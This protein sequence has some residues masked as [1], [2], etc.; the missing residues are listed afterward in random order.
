MWLWKPFSGDDKSCFLRRTT[1]RI[2]CQD[3]SPSAGFNLLEI[4]GMQESFPVSQNLEERRNG[5][6]QSFTIPFIRPENT[7]LVKGP[8][9]ICSV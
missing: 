7:G 9:H 5:Y 2:I 4:L 6:D 1:L 8:E 3:S